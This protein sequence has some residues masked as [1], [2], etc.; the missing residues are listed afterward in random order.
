MKSK[1]IIVA[2]VIIVFASFSFVGSR[3][4]K[5]QVQAPTNAHDKNMVDKG[6]FD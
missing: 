6:Q 3:N 2:A 5:S 1:L 4:N